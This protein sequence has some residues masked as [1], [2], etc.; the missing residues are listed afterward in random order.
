LTVE[1]VGID[2]VEIKRFRH[3]ADRGGRRFLERIF[4]KAEIDYCIS[5]RDPYPHMAGRF[6]VKE[7]VLKSLGLGLGGGVKLRDIE[8]CLDARGKPYVEIHGLLKE[9][10]DKPNGNRILVSISHTREYATAIAILTNS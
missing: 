2:I 4:T 10:K 6:C 3:S 7:A 9:Y 8:V 5:M 1:G